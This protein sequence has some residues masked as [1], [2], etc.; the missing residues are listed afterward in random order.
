[1]R[2]DDAAFTAFVQ[3]AEPRL[4]RALVALRGVD[5]GRDAVAE[6]LAWAYEH[7]DRV[8]R[9]E[10]PVGYL[11]RVGQS[12]S[13]PWRRRLMPPPEPVRIPEV[14]PALPGALAALTQHQRNVVWLVHGC[15]WSYADTATALGISASAVGTHVTR[16][17]EKLRNAL[18]V[19]LDA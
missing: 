7:W 15:G 6:A 3:D 19:Q 1:V 8:E 12:R 2:A 11:F 4:R 17:L 13:R 16:A 18:E 5:D 14:E 9:M 10:N